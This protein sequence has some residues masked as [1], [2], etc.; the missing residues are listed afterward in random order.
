MKEYQFNV[1][2]LTDLEK[3]IIKF[4]VNLGQ[5]SREIKVNLSSQNKLKLKKDDFLIGYTIW[6]GYEVFFNPSLFNLEDGGPIDII[7]YD[8]PLVKKEGSLYKISPCEG[9]Y[10]YFLYL[11][12]EDSIIKVISDTSI[13]NMEELNNSNIDL[14]HVKDPPKALINEM[15]DKKYL[16]GYIIKSNID[17][18]LLLL[19]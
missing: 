1:I 16:G 4:D 6:G 12:V 13:I 17:N 7:V 14:T 8:R 2:N 18:S 10:K 15:R 5:D 3:I 11:L 19:N 9:V